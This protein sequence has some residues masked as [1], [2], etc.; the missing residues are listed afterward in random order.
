MNT[1]LNVHRLVARKRGQLAKLADILEEDKRP[2]LQEIYCKRFF[3][4]GA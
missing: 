3:V 1:H 4:R 2:M